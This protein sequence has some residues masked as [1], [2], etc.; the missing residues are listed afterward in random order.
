QTADHAPAARSPRTARNLGR[1]SSP[2]PRR[3]SLVSQRRGGGSAVK[4]E[5]RLRRCKLRIHIVNILHA[6]IAHP[7][8]QCL[9]PWLGVNRNPVLPSSPPAQPSRK[10]HAPFRFTPSKVG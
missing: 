7:I 5:P 6:L 4:T 1:A 3:A 10:L 9:P 8:L 2:P